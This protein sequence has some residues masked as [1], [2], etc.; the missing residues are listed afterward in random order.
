MFE[1]FKSQSQSSSKTRLRLRL[2]LRLKKD[3]K[4]VESKCMLMSSN[5][6]ETRYS[7]RCE[8]V[9]ARY[10]TLMKKKTSICPKRRS[11]SNRLNG[12]F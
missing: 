3:L 4:F 7:P 11:V 6:R 10:R 5:E 12:K 1:S 8:G 9:D 2:R